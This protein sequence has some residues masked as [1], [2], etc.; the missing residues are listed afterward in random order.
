MERE[1]GGN[2]AREIDRGGGVADGFELAALGGLVEAVA[3]LALDRRHADG[4]HSKEARA[5]RGRNL[6]GARGPHGAHAGHDA[7]AGGRDGLVVGACHAHRIL[8]V[9][10]A[11]PGRVGVRVHEAGGDHAVVRGH[12][13]GRV[14]G[15]GIGARADVG[16]GAAVD[17]DRAVRDDAERIGGGGARGI[18]GDDAGRGQEQHD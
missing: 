2:D 16:D 9:A 18:A 14:A 17:Q 3:A 5:Q 15:H 1:V 8:A 10:R 7:A 11:H 13:R 12:G 6:V 4:R